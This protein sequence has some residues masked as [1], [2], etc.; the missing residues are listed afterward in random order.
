MQ[1]NTCVSILQAATQ[2]VRLVALGL[3]LALFAGPAAAGEI[4]TSSQIIIDNFSFAPATLTV[5][6]GTQVTWVNHDDIPHTVVSE[7]KVTFKSPAL[8]LSL[9]HI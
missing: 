4:P 5:P 9:I 7:D 8:D 2:T 1:P 6:V 3:T